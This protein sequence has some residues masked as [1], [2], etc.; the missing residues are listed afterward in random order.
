[1]FMCATEMEKK[2]EN[3]QSKYVRVCERD[4]EE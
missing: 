3:G 4:E 1:M 2:S